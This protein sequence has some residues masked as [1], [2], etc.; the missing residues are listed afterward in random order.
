MNLA[1]TKRN[2]L[3]YQ[4]VTSG[5]MSTTSITSAVTNIQLLDNIGIQLNWSGSPVG[6]FAIQVS[7]DYQQDAEGNVT[8]TGNWVPLV[9][10]YWNG[11]TF[12]TDT[13]VP[14]SVGSPIYLDLT[15]LSSAWIRVVYT[16]VS[17]TGT[18]N[19]FLT[20]KQI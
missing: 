5:D 14:S 17:G 20:A 2:I 18:L 4:S 8:S 10:T 3:K 1:S 9:L 12:I 11:T 6:S 15:Q 13:S 16:K 19:M 7:A